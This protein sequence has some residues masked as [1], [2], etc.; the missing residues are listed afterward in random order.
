MTDTKPDTKNLKF[1]DL[2]QTDP[3]DFNKLQ[4][5]KV[6][7]F[8]EENGREKYYYILHTNKHHELRRQRTVDYRLSEEQLEKLKTDKLLVTNAINTERYGQNISAFGSHVLKLYHNDMPVFVTSDMMLYALHRFYDKSL[9]ILEIELI[10]EFKCLCE[11]LLTTIQSIDVSQLDVN[12]IN[13]LKGLEL[14]LAVPYFLLNYSENTQR[15][16]SQPKIV[17]LSKFKMDP[18]FNSTEEV[19]TICDDIRNLKLNN[20]TIN[21]V[22]F[23]FNATTFKPRGHY[24]KST[25][26]ENYFMAFTWFS[27]CI[28]KLNKNNPEDYKNGF[29]F[30]S[31]LCEIAKQ[32]IFQVQKIEHFVET[33]IGKPDGYTLSSFS[34]EIKINTN[35]LDIKNFFNKIDDLVENTVLT[36]KC[37]LTKVG[38]AGLTFDES[39]RTEYCFSLIGKGTTFDNAVIN[40]M[41][42]VEFNK[43][44]GLDRKFPSIFDIT[45]ALF[46]NESTLDFVRERMNC[47]TKNGRDGIKYDEY[48]ESVK[49]HMAE[50]NIIGTTLYNQELVML[51]ALSNLSNSTTAHPNIEPFNSKAWGYKQAQ[52]QIGHY[53]EIRHDNV[54]YLDECGGMMMCCEYPDIMIEPCLEFWKEFLNL[55]KMME[56]MFISLGVKSTTNQTQRIINNFKSIVGKF[57][58]FSEYFLAG[59]EIPNELKEELK[60]ILEYQSGG[61]GPPT[62]SGWYPQLFYDKEESLEN[63]SEVSSYFTAVNDDRGSG[64][65]CHLGNGDVQLMYIVVNDT[66]YIGPVYTVYDIITPFEVRYN[67]AEWEKQRKKYKPLDFKLKKGIINVQ[68][69]NEPMQILNID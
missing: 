68:N 54:L 32:S 18:K 28:V 19:K 66:I 51:K 14:Y 55:I 27:K 31:L 43:N 6:N 39:N 36:N 48:L 21:N 69:S 50:S 59:Q 60:C 40:S 3:K 34:S 53:N 58:V 64:G 41:V 46:N 52:T 57:I 11:S 35:E 15:R 2:I 47:P 42:D 29:I 26:L 20:L 24:S 56:V 62:Y 5:E 9:E 61:S 38:D 16:Y 65:I 10:K 37:K 30:S 17:E 4:S 13:H 12:I 63:K 7:K 23:S 33:L 1:L 67:D 25:N 49:Q 45:Y 22:N 8:I 44:T